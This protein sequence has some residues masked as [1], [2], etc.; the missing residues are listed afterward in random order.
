MDL[1]AY[2]S[3][4]H[5]QHRAADISRLI[6]EHGETALD[7]GAREGFFSKMLAQRFDHVIALDLEQPRIV[8]DR[9]ECVQG[10]VTALGYADGAFDFVLCSE[11]LEH[12]P[13]PRL[14]KACSE[15]ARVSRRFLVIG[16]PYKQDLR[17]GRTTCR[18]CRR[19][20]PP[21]GHVNSFDEARLA[22]LFEGCEVCETSFVDSVKQATNGLSVRL[23][24]LAGNP[25]GTYSQEEPCI[26]CGAKLVNPPERTLMQKVATRLAFY[27]RRPSM[28]RAEAHANWIHLLLV[29]TS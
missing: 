5:E 23:M 12:V 28:R 26:H 6:P 16:V 9:I 22:S 11:V 7:V 10:D 3:S 25:Y 15:L 20:N 29:K 13:T 2:R 18:H 24:D 21:W 17:V 1:Q 4:T 14:K 8:D 27:A 19:S